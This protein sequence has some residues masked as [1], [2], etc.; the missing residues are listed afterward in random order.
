MCSREVLTW[1]AGTRGESKGLLMVMSQAL[2]SAVAVG[3]AEPAEQVEQAAVAAED[4][5]A[6]VNDQG[7][8]KS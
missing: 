6:S 7:A 8:K 5:K 3:P 4:Y 2:M 1:E